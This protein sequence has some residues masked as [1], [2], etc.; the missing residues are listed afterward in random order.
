MAHRI[1]IACYEVPG[2]GGAGTIAYELFAR[3]QADGANVHCVSLVKE[4]D[5]PRLRREFGPLL[6]NPRQLPSVSTILVDEPRWRRQPALAALV[7]EFQPDLIL[8]LGVPAMAFVSFIGAPCRQALFTTGS[9]RMR[10]LLKAGAVRDFQDWRHGAAIGI[11]YGH[12]DELERR[13]VDAADFIFVHSPIVRELFEHFFPDARG[14]I[15][16]DLISVADFCYAEAETY[17]D[18][19][20]P[21]AD[22]EIDVLFVS[23]SWRRHVKNYPMVRTLAPRLGVRTY[24]IGEVGDAIPSVEYGGV[25][26]ERAEVF[27]RMGMAKVVVSPS[28]FDAAPGVLF[29]ATA[30]GANVVATPNCGNWELCHETLRAQACTAADLE[31]CIRRGLNEKLP[32]CRRRFLGGYRE[33]VDTLEVL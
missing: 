33:L 12:E 6:G 19:A 31:E 26:G 14:R 29:E 15:H 17:T 23:S 25:T 13:A 3:M 32:D 7:E 30:L 2:Q 20:L 9:A 10:R 4:A 22:R 27:R 21:F 5:A 18:L 1:L 28:L 8:C 16:E 11:R 24:V